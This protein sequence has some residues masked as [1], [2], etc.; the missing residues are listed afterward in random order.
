MEKIYLL[1]APARGGKNTCAEAM[2]EYYEATYHKKVIII[3]F[4]DYVKFVLDKYYNTP[5]ER[6]EEYRTRI[7]QFATDQVRSVN[8]NYWTDVVGDLLLCIQED[9][10][11]VIIPD[12]RFKNERISLLTRFKELGISLYTLLIERPNY[13]EIDGMTEEQ[14]QHLSERDLDNYNNYDYI[15]INET[16]KIQKT[17]QQLIDMIDEVENKDGDY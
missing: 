11:V 10:D 4:A 7:Q 9:W 14:R 2:K 3:A 5:A 15:I 13:K 17:I 6:T 8:V 1:H 16:S 12:F